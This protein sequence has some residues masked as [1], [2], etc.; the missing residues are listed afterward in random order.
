VP[1]VAA[2]TFDPGDCALDGWPAGLRWVPRAALALRPG[3]SRAP[4]TMS[5]RR[6]RRVLANDLDEDQARS[7]VSRLVPDAPGFLT[8]PMPGPA[9][10]PEVPR[11]YLLTRRDRIHKPSRQAAIA[12]RLKA[13]V[14]EIDSGRDPMLSQPAAVAAIIN[15]L[16]GIPRRTSQAGMGGTEASD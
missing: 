10:P 1:Q 3:G 2:S 8:S 9:V 7:L 15:G 5:A 6:A 4:L 16:A 14:V 13:A 11:T 12:A